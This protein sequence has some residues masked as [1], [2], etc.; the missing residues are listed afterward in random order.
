MKVLHLF[1]KQTGTRP[2][3]VTI[4]KRYAY[5]WEIGSFLSEHEDVIS[6]DSID[7]RY[8]IYDLSKKVSLENFEVLIILVRIENIYQTI[9]FSKFI[10]SIK[11][12]IK[13]IVYGDIV[14]HIPDFF[15]SVDSI[16][17]LVT[18]GDWELSLLS[19]INFVK[20]GRK[21]LKGVYDKKSK[22]ELPGLSLGNKWNFP[23]LDYIPYNL[24]NKLNGKKELTLTIS[25]GCPYDC[26]FCMSTITFGN[27]DRRKDIKEILNYIKRNNKK[28]ESF[29]LFS[30][31]FNLDNDWV[32]DFCN[33]I[34]ERKLK[35]KWS[36]T[37]RIDLLDNKEVV[38]LMAKAGCYKISVGI[39]S[40]N[41]SAKYL[42]K[43]FHK[44]QIKRV[45][46][47]FRSNGMILKG[48]VM[49]GVKNQTK[50]D[51]IELFRLMKDNKVKI[52]PTS[53]SPMEELVKKIKPTNEE[54]QQYDKFTFYKS[55]IKGISKEIYYNLIFDPENFEK[56]LK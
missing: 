2:I 31:T 22:K 41:K 24:Y 43:E 8:S 7:P 56:Y 50:A 16:D 42:N 11:K 21:K 17:A 45:A 1:P 51:I 29:K 40:I 44:E 4:P 38:K 5:F 48:L 13:I 15:K 6:I 39:E 14:N 10:K 53:Y 46:R 30:P 28:F 3:H 36:S 27:K 49:L 32:V 26:R 23:N 37:S 47:Y 20:D 54:I 34:I 12:N 25:R 52:R 18:S 19:Y 9:N 33:E 55:G 35:I